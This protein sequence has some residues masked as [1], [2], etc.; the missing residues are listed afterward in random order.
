MAQDLPI[1]LV[2][3]LWAGCNTAA[4]SYQRLIERRNVILTGKIG[5][6][7]ISLELRQHMLVC[8]WR[9]E[10]I[11]G[12]VANAAF[13]LAI[14]FVPQFVDLGTQANWWRAFAS[15]P[16]LAILGWLTFGYRDQNYMKKV[17]D[18][19]VS[20]ASEEAARAEKKMEP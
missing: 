9:S 10:W 13:T 5:A 18:A 3:A 4:T 7:K 20:R 16:S 12:I 15:F 11:A 14:L 8:D 1:A 17:L 2:A 6:E 19:E